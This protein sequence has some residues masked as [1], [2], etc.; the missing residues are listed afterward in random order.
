MS[1]ETGHP[2]VYPDNIDRTAITAAL[3]T[4]PTD[5]DRAV[6]GLESFLDTAG[7]P[8]DVDA[9]VESQATAA[10]F[11]ESD[12]TYETFADWVHSDA[13]RDLTVY[14]MP[15]RRPDGH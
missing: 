8:W 6:A 1:R 15:Q 7:Y 11:W 2:V 10:E 14:R 5:R 9:I 13:H 4:L 3:S 12:V